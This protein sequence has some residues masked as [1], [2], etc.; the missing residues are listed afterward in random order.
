MVE[1]I[2]Q[3]CFHWWITTE[4]VS[5]YKS[6]L[7]TKYPSIIQPSEPA[8]SSLHR[9]NQEYSTNGP[10]PHSMDKEADW[11][12]PASGLIWAFTTDVTCLNVSPPHDFKR[13]C[14]RPL[15][16]K[17]KKKSVIYPDPEVRTWELFIIQPSCGL[18]RMTLVSLWVPWSMCSSIQLTLG[19]QR[20]WPWRGEAS[21]WL[22]Q[23]SEVLNTDFLSPTI[24]VVLFNIWGWALTPS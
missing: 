20:A 24:S 4:S 15:E 7:E 21:P 12:H 19:T 11:E 16:N 2:T 10:S 3:F 14:H 9:Y 17:K 23:P 8:K 6:P 1:G 22:R 5:L 13:P 18:S